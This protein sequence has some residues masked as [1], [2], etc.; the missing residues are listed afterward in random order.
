MAQAQRTDQLLESIMRDTDCQYLSDLHAR[1]YQRCVHFAIAKLDA[2]RFPLDEWR[3]A[4]TYIAGRQLD[5]D[6]AE[7]IKLRLLNALPEE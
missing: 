3:R 4:A 7:E 2:A 1:T 6:S 5:G